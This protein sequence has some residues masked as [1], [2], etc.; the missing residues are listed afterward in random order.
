MGAARL[1][2]NLKC[3]PESRFVFV[4]RVKIGMV[5][6]DVR[7]QPAVLELARAGNLQALA[8]WLNSQLAPY[9]LYARLSYVRPGYLRVLVELRPSQQR[10]AQVSAFRTRLVRYICHQ[11]WQLNSEALDGAYVVARYIGQPQILWKQ[12]VRI[13]SPA[14]RRQLASQSASQPASQP[15]SRST[16]SLPAR[17]KQA[18]HSQFQAM[19][20]LLVSGSAA[21][22]F[23]LGCWLGY[24]DAPSEQ[25]QATALSAPQTWSGDRIQTAL[26]T[27]PVIKPSPASGDAAANLLFGGDVSDPATGNSYSWD[28]GAIDDLRR[29]DISMVNL[30]TPLT[31]ATVPLAGQKS[32]LKAGP[33]RAPALRGS[34]INLVNLANSH[35]MDFSTTG[36]DDTLTTLQKAG[37]ATIGAGRNS[38]EARRPV[39]MEVKG[40]RI[41]YLGY[42]D[43][44]RHAATEQAAGTNPRHND[45]IA[46]DIK[47][48]RSQVD[49]IV[50]NFHWGE[51]LAK[52]PGDWQIDMARFTIDQGADLVVG[53]HAKVLQG[54]EV[55]KGRPI[56]YS[57]GNFLFGNRP[58]TDKAL[59][60]QMTAKDT[61]AKDLAAKDTAAKDVVE[62][63]T[64]GSS[65]YDTAVLKVALKDKQMKVEFLPLEVRN[66]QARVL[67]GERA[68]QVLHQINNVSDIFQQPLSSP[69]LL[70]A[71]TNEAK[72]LSKVSPTGA[73]TEPAAPAESPLPTSPAAGTP[74]VNPSASP[75]Q[76]GGAKPWNSDSFISDPARNRTAVP[77][78]QEYA[79]TPS[80]VAIDEAPKLP[81]PAAAAP[82]S[83][84]VNPP[85]VS[86][87]SITPST[88]STP[89]ESP[90]PVE[91]VAP[92]ESPAPVAE[93][94]ASPIS[95]ESAAPAVTEAA[96]SVEIPAAVAPTP[97]QSLEPI[98]RR[99]AEAEPAQPDVAA[100]LPTSH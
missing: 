44:D 5:N 45:K 93:S 23:I 12:S 81:L 71:R 59:A 24:A 82:E 99:Y 91:S 41:A 17:I 27:V 50:V 48:L 86:A 26:E 19:R 66:Y 51:E 30:D 3:H 18:Q 33:D 61:A 74:L 28:L 62:K 47:A 85:A 88:T 34:G 90:A 98:K 58:T 64:Q 97:V 42:Y 35:A 20:S 52:Y 37:I 57:L 78:S 16:L 21:A 68:E 40:Q 1:G 72:P 89:V 38:Q 11:L 25:T 6:A 69:M 55:Y 84:A 65:D 29:S 56:V 67:K 96:R 10:D 15:A 83:V 100:S 87:A 54:A 60:D 94:S 2:M 76:P 8:Y 39:I 63:A 4:L 49:W 7:H 79:A 70:D 31:T 95:T 77:Q 80:Q 36:L 73:P 32:V 75:D 22:A 9:K 14:R 92:V 13:V 43:A 53:H 46:A